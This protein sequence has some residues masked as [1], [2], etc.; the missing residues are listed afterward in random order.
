MKQIWI[1]ISLILFGF[2][3]LW[4][5]EESTS[6]SLVS[7]L[8]YWQMQIEPNDY[9]HNFLIIFPIP[10]DD[11]TIKFTKGRY[12]GDTTDNGTIVL[13]PNQFINFNKIT[14]IDGTSFYVDG[15]RIFTEGNVKISTTDGKKIIKVYLSKVSSLHSDYKAEYELV[16]DRMTL[17]NASCTRL[18]RSLLFFL[19]TIVPFSVLAGVVF[20]LVGIYYK[21]SRQNKPAL[22]SFS[23]K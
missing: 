4:Q 18:L 16:G 11:G 22:G 6:Y 19:F 9:A 14:E 3:W 15:Y 1:G 2:A 5:F 21:I 10:Q 12:L 7:K 17:L 23:E 8:V 13:T 20:I